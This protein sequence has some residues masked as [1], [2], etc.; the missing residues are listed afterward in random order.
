MLCHFQIAA[1]VAPLVLTTAACGRPRLPPPDPAVS[2]RV[3]VTLEGN[4][5]ANLRTFVASHVRISPWPALPSTWMPGGGSGMVAFASERGGQSWVFV[6]DESSTAGPSFTVFPVSYRKES[7]PVLEP[8]TRVASPEPD[9]APTPPCE[10]WSGF[11]L[12]G[13]GD[14]PVS[15]IVVYRWPH[16][17]ASRSITV[18]PARHTL[19]LRPVLHFD[20]RDV[21]ALH[22]LSAT[23][24]LGVTATPGTKPFLLLGVVKKPDGWF[25]ETAIVPRA[26]EQGWG[27]FVHTPGETTEFSFYALEEPPALHSACRA[28]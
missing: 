10:W 3:R 22:N 6:V 16:E 9:A 13:V 15:P 23:I 28:R 11:F 17:G 25:I 27:G 21:G 4:E 26:G 19:N 12:K 1:L 5:D 8:V 7:E 24:I 14:L 20:T 2:L 18:D